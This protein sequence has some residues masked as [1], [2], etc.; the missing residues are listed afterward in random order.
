MDGDVVVCF[1]RADGEV[2]LCRREANTNAN[3]GGWEVPSGAVEGES[4]ADDVAH[5]LREEWTIGDAT[6]VRVGDPV[7]VGESRL[8]PYLFDCESNEPDG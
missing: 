1:L 4:S 2:L 5:E 8:H 3:G 6:P 7:T